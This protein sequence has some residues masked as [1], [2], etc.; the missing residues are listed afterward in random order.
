[1][2]QKSI[3]LISLLFYV[4]HLQAHY[5]ID[6]ERITA[7]DGLSSNTINCILQDKA[8]YIWIGTPNGLDRY[9]GYSLWNFSKDK[10]NHARLQGESIVGMHEDRTNKMLWIFT[11]GNQARCINLNNFTLTDYCEKKEDEQSYPY[12]HAG[13]LYLWR[14]GK[15]NRCQRIRFVNNKFVVENFKHQ[16]HQICSDEEGNDWILSEK[17]IYLNGFEECLPESDSV[18]QIITYHG[19]CLGITHSQII[20]YNHSRRVVRKTSLPKVFHGLQSSI[21]ASVWIDKLLLLGPKNTYVYEIIDGIFSTLPDLQLTEGK[22]LQQNNSH[23][24]YIY[25]KKGVLYRLGEDEKINK[26]KIFA[27]KEDCQAQWQI[28]HL[29]QTT[30]ALSAYGHGLYLLDLAN[31]NIVHYHKDDQSRLVN[32][33]CL[34]GLMTDHSGALWMMEENLGLSIL[35]FNN[36]SS[37]R[38]FI[39]SASVMSEANHLTTLTRN[40]EQS[41]CIT[42]KRNE[43]YSYDLQKNK[44]TF[45]FQTKETIQ[46]AV[47]DNNY[48]VWLGTSDGVWH[49]GTPLKPLWPDSLSSMNV[50]AIAVDEHKSAYL[51]LQDGSIVKTSQLGDNDFKFECIFQTAAPVRTII[52][53]ITGKMWVSTTQELLVFESDSCRSPLRFRLNSTQAPMY[54]IVSSGCGIDEDIWIGTHGYGLFSCTLLGKDLHCQR[55]SVSEGLISN[56]INSLPRDTRG[57]LW[58]ATDE[59][60]SLVSRHGDNIRNF[61]FHDNPLGNLYSSNAYT[62]VDDNLYLATNDGFVSIQTNSISES[63][64]H[65]DVY[66]TSVSLGNITQYSCNEPM[67][68]DY[69]RQEL[70]IHFS[71]LHHVNTN[72]CRYQYRLDGI[73]N[74]WSSPSD[75]HTA[76]YKGLPPG[77]YT[78]YV[79]SVHGCKYCDTETY[80][81]L[82]IK[83]PWWSTWPAMVGCLL[84]LSV[85]GLF[86]VYLWKRHHRISMSRH[87][88]AVTQAVT[89]RQMVAPVSIPSTAEEVESIPQRDKRFIERIRFILEKEGCHSDFTVEELGRKMGLGRTRFYTRVKEATGQTPSELLRKY[90]LEV[91]ARLLLETDDNIE[92]IREKCGFGNATNFYNYFKRQ[93]ELSPQRYRKSEGKNPESKES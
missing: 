10:E 20:I 42:N 74:E 7:K 62:F 82:V 81:L 31:G 35:H 79:R 51:G 29:N 37:Q 56:N 2:K 30:E 71:N 48:H 66:V 1:M 77:E 80:C 33:N 88:L 54:D 15:E 6:K 11:S 34:T 25:D 70:T 69:S 58:V 64:I 18:K 17:G 26:W 60:L 3:L 28:S 36:L 61:Y 38:Y 86:F 41:L 40:G 27:E 4:V 39:Q 67:T 90:R 8:G 13:K 85:L 59:G 84:L 63:N 89:G 83:R 93:Y 49:D 22:I 91:A 57:W 50:N 73:D 32:N 92:E 78:F 46:C 53:D 16:I 72:K 9:D 21:E 75:E 43:V 65:S 76:S 55:I 5:K 23:L 52:H 24:A 87:S 14:Y 19:L 44:S 45:L 47:S 68:F 12:Y